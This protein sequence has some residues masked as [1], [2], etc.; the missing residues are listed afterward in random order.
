MC[1]GGFNVDIAYARGQVTGGFFGRF[2]HPQPVAG[3]K[4]QRHRQRHHLTGRV[5]ALHWRELAAVGLI[6]FH[7]QR[8]A[9]LPE[10]GAQRSKRLFIAEV[11]QRHLQPQGVQRLGFAKVAGQIRVERA[12]R[13]KQGRRGGIARLQAQQCHRFPQRWQRQE[14][15]AAEQLATDLYAVC[16][17]R[18][19]NGQHGPLSPCLSHL[20]R[21]I[22]GG[23]N[24]YLSAHFFAPS[25]RIVSITL[26]GTG[27]KEKIR[28][29]NL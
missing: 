29:L 11:T 13:H 8:D 19:N 27:S 20:F 21:A 6:V 5:K 26:D 15:V 28:I 14:L 17:C 4:G 22:R 24:H 12:V 18:R 9:A 3:I 23:D 10:Q 2:T 25:R 1:N 7:H 16:P